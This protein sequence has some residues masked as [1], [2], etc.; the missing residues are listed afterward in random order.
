MRFRARRVRR[1]LLVTLVVVAGLLVAA[2]IVALQVYEARSATGLARSTAA[3]KASVDLGGSPFLPSYVRERLDEV[4][5]EALG[6]TRGGL[7]VD[8]LT[9]RM[10]DVTFERGPAWALVRS[11]YSTRMLVTGRE[12]VGR[13][14]VV[15]RDL[16]DYLRS[17]VPA[18]REVRITQ[19]GVEVSFE[20]A[21]GQGQPPVRYLPRVVTDDEE[22][23]PRLTLQLLGATE[24][25]RERT[26]D[27]RAIEG[28]IQLPRFP[29]GLQGTAELGNGVFI[30]EFAGAE[31]S[32]WVGAGRGDDEEG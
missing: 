10:R 5:V 28:V 19:S 16:S 21:E 27:A 3:Q 20:G 4:Q 24:V 26:A 9:L 14:D 7:R 17:R 13:F 12:V 31:A 22:G 30:V 18:V 25:P 6:M 8:R 29:A 32:L 2:D 11:L 1:Y 23:R 15:E